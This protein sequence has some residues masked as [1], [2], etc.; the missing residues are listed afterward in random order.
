MA[1]VLEAER[2]L[3]PMKS[4]QDLVLAKSEDFAGMQSLWF[5]CC[6]LHTRLRFPGASIGNEV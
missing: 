5:W 4:L 6:R 2:E 1:A 3:P